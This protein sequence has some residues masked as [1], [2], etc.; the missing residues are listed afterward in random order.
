MPVTYPVEID[1]L[2]YVNQSKHI[3]ESI[4]LRTGALHAGQAV[5]AVWQVGTVAALVLYIVCGFYLAF[6]SDG[7]APKV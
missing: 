6:N 7:P 2:K 1:G 4:E 5:V 3:S